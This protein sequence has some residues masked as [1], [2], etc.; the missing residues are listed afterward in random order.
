MITKKNANRMVI[1]YGITT[2]FLIGFNY[3]YS[4]F[5]HGVTSPY[6]TYAFVYSLVLGVLGFVILGRLSL[7]NRTAYHLYNAGIVTLIVGSLLRGIFDIAGAD[8]TSPM[9]YFVVGI[10]FV[11][12]G[13]LMYFYHWHHT[14]GKKKCHDC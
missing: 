12:A 5:G 6:M 14:I 4:L 3:L 9:Y 1:I 2:L 13:G 11:I 10:G 8:S 7:E